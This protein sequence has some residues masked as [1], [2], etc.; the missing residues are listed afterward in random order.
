MRHEVMEISVAFVAIGM[1]LA[2]LAI[3]LS[4]VWHPLP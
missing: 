3:L 2:A 1:A 4:L